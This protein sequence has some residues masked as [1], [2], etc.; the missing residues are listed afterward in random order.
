VLYVDR[1]GGLALAV[2][3]IRLEHLEGLHREAHRGEHLVAAVV[4]GQVVEDRHR[5]QLIAVEQRWDLV[6]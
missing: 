5:G 1:A 6:T 2:D 4:A 3:R